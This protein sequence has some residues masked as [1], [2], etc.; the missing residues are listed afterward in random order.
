MRPPLFFLY[1]GGEKEEGKEGRGENLTPNN[2]RNAYLEVGKKALLWEIG[3]G[4]GGKLRISTCMR[5]HF[6]KSDEEAGLF[7]SM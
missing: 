2:H 7:Q 4:G 5:K 6:G 3:R 1:G